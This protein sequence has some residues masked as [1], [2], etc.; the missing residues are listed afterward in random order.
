M[1]LPVAHHPVQTAAE[2]RWGKVFL[3]GSRLYRNC[4]LH[5][6]GAKKM[7]QPRAPFSSA[8][9]PKRTLATLAI[10]VQNYRRIGERRSSPVAT[11]RQGRRRF[12]EESPCG[13]LILPGYTPPGRCGQV[14][15]SESRNNDRM[16]TVRVSAQSLVPAIRISWFDV[17]H[18]LRKGYPSA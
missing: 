16:P 12:G 17:L 18:E 8:P 4:L 14:L 15:T 9:H 10:S 7:L 3:A 5:L 6:T 1:F 13:S 11:R 2:I